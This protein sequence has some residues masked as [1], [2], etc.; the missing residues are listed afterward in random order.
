[1]IRAAAA[2]LAA[3]AFATPVTAQPAAVLARDTPVALAVVDMLNSQAR[4]QGDRFAL[5]VTEDVTVAGQVVIPRG[6]PGVGEIV[7]LDRKAS[8][9]RNGRIRVR[10]LYVELGARRLPLAGEPSTVERGRAGEAWGQ[11]ALGALG[12]FFVTGRSAELPSGHPMRGYVMHDVPLRT[13]AE[14]AAA[15]P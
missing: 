10:P 8:Y 14:A 9:G 5:T 3:A 6:T 11:A 4:L 2:V 15:R 12:G 7:E 1:M 13:R